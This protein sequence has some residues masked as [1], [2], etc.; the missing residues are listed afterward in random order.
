MSAELFAGQLDP[1]NNHVP[2]GLE[3]PSAFRKQVAV[4]DLNAGHVAA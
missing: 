2:I 4:L 1:Q 3:R